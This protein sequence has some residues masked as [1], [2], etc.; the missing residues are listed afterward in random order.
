M[1]IIAND[2]GDDN[3]SPPKL[4]NSQIEKQLVRDDIT[5]DLYMPLFSTIVL[6][7]KKM[8]SVPLDFENGLTIDALAVSRPYVSAIAQTELVIMKQLAPGNIIK[9]D[10]PPNFQIQVANGQLE[11]PISTTTLKIDIGDNTF[12]ENFVVMKKLTGPNIGLH[13]MRHNNVVIDTPHGLIHF[14]H[15][16]MAAKN[17][18]IEASAK[19]Q[20]IPIHDNTTVPPMT[21][22]TITAFVDHPSEWH[23]TGT[24]TPVAKFTE[25]ASLLISHSVS[26]I[27]D[28]KTAVR[29]TNTTE[30]PY[31]IKK[32]TQIAE[33]SVVNPEKSKFIRPVDTSILSMIPEGDPDLTT[34]LSELLGTTKPEQQSKTFWFPTPKNP[35]TTE[36]HTPIQTRIL[37]E[38]CELQKKERLNP[39]DDVKSR[40]KILKRFDWTDTLLTEYEKHAVENILVSWSST[41]IYLADKEWTLE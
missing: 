37:K 33:F 34:Y 32:N 17:A 19:P 2:I 12:A 20:A 23:T 4:T 6:K 25:A 28:K 27:I 5:K 10:D 11:K 24:V 8:L 21:T 31:L 41:M 35:G 40:T 1:N 16:T 13:F 29:I 15:L 39:K 30:S 14:P 18:A 38:L 3:I 7:R 26:T 22:E 36:E 9:I